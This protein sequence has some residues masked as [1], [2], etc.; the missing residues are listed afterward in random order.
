MKREFK[1]IVTRIK[2]NPEQAILV[3]PCYNTLYQFG[4]SAPRR[5]VCQG[6]TP[7]NKTIISASKYADGQGNS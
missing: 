5:D 1:P 3:C 4:T 6:D 2:L 7:A